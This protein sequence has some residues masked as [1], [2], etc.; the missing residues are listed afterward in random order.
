MVGL[1][2]V[3]RPFKVLYRIILFISI[4]MIHSRFIFWIPLIK[5]EKADTEM[6][7]KS[8]Y[9]NTER[10][11]RPPPANVDGKPDDDIADFLKYC[12]N[13]LNN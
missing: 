9:V 10:R 1:F 2:F 11:F 13:I 7:D 12:E 5:A 8:V 3:S 4:F 6:K